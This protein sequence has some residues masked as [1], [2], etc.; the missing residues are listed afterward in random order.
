[1]PEIEGTE[2]AK[3]EPTKAKRT[4]VETVEDEVGEVKLAIERM[5]DAAK[6]AKTDAEVNKA[7]LAGLVRVGWKTTDD[8]LGTIEG[9]ISDLMKQGDDDL[10][11]VRQ[12]ISTNEAN[13]GDLIRV[14]RAESVGLLD[15]NAQAIQDNAALAV[16]RITSVETKLLAEIRIW[17][18]MFALGNALAWLVQR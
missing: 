5:A 9:K 16:A 10:R 1:M 12:E 17:A 13:L 4:I 2:A 11:V 8:R 18:F 7:E 15:R 6:V 3:P 14:A